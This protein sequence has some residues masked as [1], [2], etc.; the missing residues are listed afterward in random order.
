MCVS[1]SS[2]ARAG[3][4]H[5]GDADGSTKRE[6]AGARVKSESTGAGSVV[7][8]W[9]WGTH[10]GRDAGHGSGGSGAGMQGMQDR[11][12]RLLFAFEDLKPTANSGAGGGES[13][14]GSGA[15]VDGGDHQFE[16]GNKEQQGNGTPV[17]QPD[18]PGFW[19]GMIGGGGTW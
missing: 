16:Q 8:A 12:G 7:G 6:P 19:N 3:E 17:G 10:E 11:S 13:G 15:G 5:G 9:G 2:G 1:V 14:G 18:T 4:A